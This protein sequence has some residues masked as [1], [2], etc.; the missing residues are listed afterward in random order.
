MILIFKL[1]TGNDIM[2]DV[3]IDCDHLEDLDYNP[4]ITIKDPMSIESDIEGLRLRDC[5]ILS[6]QNTLVFRTQNILTY[7]KP[8]D[9]MV[10]Y[11]KKAVKHSKKHTRPTAKDYILNAAAEV[12]PPAKAFDEEQTARLTAALL[13]AAGTKLQ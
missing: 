7:Y 9:N 13:K 12:D 10:K 11:Y 5:L 4:Y 3:Q 1:T 2:G 8:F 6:D